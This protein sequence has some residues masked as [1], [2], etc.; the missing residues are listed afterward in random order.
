MIMPNVVPV[1]IPVDTGSLNIPEWLGI[2]IVC[3]CEA[4]LVGGFGLFVYGVIE[5]IYDWDFGVAIVLGIVALL[6]LVAIIL[7][8]GWL[9]GRM[10]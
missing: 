5:C 7:T 6:T 1:V 9:I 4:I 2:T 3:I 8:G 10:Q